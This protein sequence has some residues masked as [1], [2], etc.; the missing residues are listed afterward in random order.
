[1]DTNGNEQGD[2]PLLYEGRAQQF[3]FQYYE[4]EPPKSN[5]PPV[6]EV[7]EPLNAQVNDLEQL[8][9][10][11][12]V[13]DERNEIAHITLRMNAQKSKRTCFSEFD[14]N[15][16]NEITVTKN[17]CGILESEIKKDN[18]LTDNKRPN[19][20]RFKIN[21]NEAPASEFFQTE[22]KNANKD[23]YTVNIEV[24]DKE[25]KIGKSNRGFNLVSIPGVGDVGN[26]ACLGSGGCSEWVGPHHPT[27]VIMD[28]SNP[29]TG[30][31]SIVPGQYSQ[32]SQT[33]P[34]GQY[35]Y[36]GAGNPVADPYGTMTGGSYSNPYDQ[37]Q[38]GGSLF[39]Q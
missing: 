18:F 15:E 5:Y 27:E 7:I 1:M 9:I 24:T 30:I 23:F 36:D 8:W 21:L 20:V 37:G 13:I 12:N 11:F 35:T 14:V 25:G 19:F 22:I 32:N 17:E 38:I 28:P 26:I 29:E 2:T 39:P 3:K 4:S 6:V 16:Q 31:Q 10:G 33:M 34:S